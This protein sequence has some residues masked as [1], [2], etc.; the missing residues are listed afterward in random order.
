MT[1]QEAIKS[2]KPFK[3]KYCTRWMTTSSPL[4][5]FR[6]IHDDN[7]VDDI[8]TIFGFD[9]LADDWEVKDFTDTQNT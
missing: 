8:A 5:H 2:G 4:E 9:V 7:K 3:R 1:I 6:Y